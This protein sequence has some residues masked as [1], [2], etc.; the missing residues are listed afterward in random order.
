MQWN[1]NLGV[2]L[3]FKISGMNT[4]RM[5]WI[6]GDSGCT[7]INLITFPSL[8]QCRCL[9]DP[10]HA[11]SYWQCVDLLWSCVSSGG[12]GD[13]PVL[14]SNPSL[15]V[16]CCGW[17]LC[18]F[19]RLR[20]PWDLHWLLTISGRALCQ[21]SQELSRMAPRGKFRKCSATERWL[22]FS[23]LDGKVGLL[24]LQKDRCWPF[25][26]PAKNIWW[27]RVSLFCFPRSWENGVLAVVGVR[28]KIQIAKA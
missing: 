7:Y 13:K 19:F 26:L 6:A 10:G 11:G 25:S 17:C 9:L 2:L 18:I 23:C 15:G 12:G 16:F 21:P 1:W 14:P 5:K 27:R 4:D 24:Y 3:R 22:P 20:S 8:A 28:R